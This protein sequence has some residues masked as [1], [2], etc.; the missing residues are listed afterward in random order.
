MSL[1]KLIFLFINLQ[2]LHAFIPPSTKSHK[3]QIH[4]QKNNPI[5]NSKPNESWYVKTET[6]KKPYPQVKPYLESH[7]TWIQKLRQEGYCI[8][9]GYRVD[10]EGR[11]GGG[12]LMIFSARDYESARELVLEDP[13]VK[14]DCVDW[15]LNGW[16]SEVGDIRLC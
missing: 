2:S 3:S 9:S 11:P 5:I 6:F 16:I 14:N 4:Q 8:T 1:Y 12:G 13:L 7:R 10:G 15:V